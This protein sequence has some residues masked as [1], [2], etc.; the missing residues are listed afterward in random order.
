MSEGFRPCD[1]SQYAAATTLGSRMHRQTHTAGLRSYTA[2]V[3][4]DI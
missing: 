2:A 3:W 4:L 1:S